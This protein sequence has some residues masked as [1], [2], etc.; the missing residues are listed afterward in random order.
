MSFPSCCQNVCCDFEEAAKQ[1][2]GNSELPFILSRIFVLTWSFL[3]L[4]RRLKASPCSCV[5]FNPM[6]VL[7]TPLNRA[8]WSHS[9]QHSLMEV[10][11]VGCS[12]GAHPVGPEW[13]QP[14]LLLAW[15]TQC[16]LAP[17]SA[18]PS[19]KQHPES[20]WQIL[21]Q[22]SACVLFCICCLLLGNIFFLF[23]WYLYGHRFL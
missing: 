13:F 9:V 23:L 5:L 21:T 4:L 2:A 6:S 3:S 22:P 18:R 10:I 16:V 14:F 8:V 15:G 17:S 20:W 7:E 12:P 11:N 19:V 1:F